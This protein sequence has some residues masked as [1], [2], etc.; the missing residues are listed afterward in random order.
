MV[1]TR[2]EKVENVTAVIPDLTVSGSEDADLLVIGWG[3]TRGHL[4]SAVSE[5]NEKG[6]K[7]A[8]A[9]FNYINPLPKNT[10]EVISKYKKVVVCEL[11]NGQFASF[12][13]SKVPGVNFLQHNKVQGQP[14]TMAELVEHFEL[15]LK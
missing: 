5:M 8:L 10:A 14:F 3:G 1:D 4:M 15:I 13:R 11:N 9:H 6:K 2:A 7:V 12:L